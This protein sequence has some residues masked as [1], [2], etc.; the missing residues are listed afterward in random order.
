MRSRREKKKR[1]SDAL[2][3]SC[4]RKLRR[5][6]E[7]FFRVQGKERGVGYISTMVSLGVERVCRNS[8]F[9][10]DKADTDIPEVKY[11]TGGGDRG[12]LSLGL[13]LRNFRAEGRTS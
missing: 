5:S 11:R 10:V 8:D 9:R 12:G 2:R 3:L 7:K 6:T 1:S 13:M 4:D